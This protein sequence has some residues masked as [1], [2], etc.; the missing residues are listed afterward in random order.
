MSPFLHSPDGSVNNL[1]KDRRQATQRDDLKH[2]RRGLWKRVGLA[3][4]GLATVATVGAAAFYVE[5]KVA[6]TG[7]ENLSQNKVTAIDRQSTLT[8]SLSHDERYNVVVYD[9]DH[10]GQIFTHPELIYGDQIIEIETR[11]VPT[12]VEQVYVKDPGSTD[13]S[14][15]PLLVTIR[16]GD[17][18]TAEG[19]LSVGALDSS[20]ITHFGGGGIN[21]IQGE[22][23][24]DGTGQRVETGTGIPFDTV[25]FV[26]EPA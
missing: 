13:K 6:P 9:G 12:N 26:N 20:R 22:A 7:V 25:W 19:I 11:D 16:E 8:L 15:I 21:T 2:A 1:S 4:A 24:R 10:E 17:G 5:N 3:I 18:T 23:K 14:E